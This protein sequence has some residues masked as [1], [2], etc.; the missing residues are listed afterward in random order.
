[1]NDELLAAIMLQGLTKNF[2]PMKLAL[3]N[4]NAIL[5][6]DYIKDKLL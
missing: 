6:T 5:T 1:M 4:L 3:E 2:E